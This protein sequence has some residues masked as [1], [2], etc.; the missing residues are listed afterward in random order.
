MKKLLYISAI[1]LLFLSCEKEDE[2][3]V[4]ESALYK[5]SSSIYN[6]TYKNF[7]NVEVDCATMSPV[8]QSN[9]GNYVF[10]KCND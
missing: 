2:T 6:T 5:P 3:C 9:I 1:A 7:E 10:V 4:C 8:R